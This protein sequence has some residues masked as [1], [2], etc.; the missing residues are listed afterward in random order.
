M[1]SAPPIWVNPEAVGQRR[2]VT[3][4]RLTITCGQCGRVD[5]IE[6]PNPD[7]LETLFADWHIGDEK[8]YLDLCPTARTTH[9]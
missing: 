3:L 8:P 1:P 6:N 2:A 9:Q 7:R 5:A 4:A